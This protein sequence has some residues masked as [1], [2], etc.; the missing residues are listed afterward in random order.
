MYSDLNDKQKDILKFIK[1]KIIEEGFPPSVR[2]IASGVGIKS[3]ST[4][5]NH[6]NVL[7]KKGYLRKSSSKNRAIEILDHENDLDFLPKKTIDIPIVGRVTAG[8]PILAVEHIEDTFPIPLEIA[9]GS[10][11]F[12]LNVKGESM[13]EAGILDGDQIIVR[14]QNYANNG[15]IVVALIDDSATVKTYYKKDDHILLQPE[16]SSMEPIRAREVVILG[17]VIGLY[18]IY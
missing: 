14:Q 10:E 1:Y 16:N 5:Y 13:I 2:E 12:M 9:A 4:V 8:E 6:I 3:T 18:R 7:E 11:V 17:K 15:D